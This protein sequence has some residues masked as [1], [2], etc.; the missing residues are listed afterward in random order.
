MKISSE[1]QSE[2]EQI[3][4]ENKRKKR[5]NHLHRKSDY[6]TL[7]CVQKMIMNQSNK[8]TQI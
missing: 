5:T 8:N 1:L 3:F 4:N 2:L 7:N 6:V